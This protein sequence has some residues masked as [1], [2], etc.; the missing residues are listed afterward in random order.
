MKNRSTLIFDVDRSRTRS[1]VVCE[2]VLLLDQCDRMGL[3]YLRS[4]GN[5]CDSTPNNNYIHP[6]HIH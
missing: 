4:R 5:A 3:R 2:L 6:R 1:G